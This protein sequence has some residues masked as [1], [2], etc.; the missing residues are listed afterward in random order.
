MSE[1]DEAAALADAVQK[2]RISYEQYFAGVERFEPLKE[3]DKVKKELRRLM[4]A[5]SNN[6]AFRFRVQTTQATLVTFENHWDRIVR[7]IEEGTFKRDKLRAQRQQ[8]LRDATADVDLIEDDVHDLSDDFEEIT[9]LED[10]ESAVADLLSKG[11]A[12]APGATRATG[13]TGA[14]ATM[15]NA[16]TVPTMGASGASAAG[17]PPAPRPV[18]SSLFTASDDLEELVAKPFGGAGASNASGSPRSPTE[19]TAPRSPTGT[20]GP[21]APRSPMEPTAPRSPIVA[22][23]P[24]APTATTAPRSPSGPTAPTAST[25]AT[26]PSSPAAPTAPRSPTA[27]TTTT[28]PRPS[29]GTTVP[30]VA[31]AKPAAAG[32]DLKKL[33]EAFTSARSKTGE[34]KPI[35]METLAETVRKQTA[36]VKAQLGCNDVEFKVAIKDGKAV[37]KAVPK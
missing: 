11:M 5:R 21:N 24:N 35:S 12:R 37:L 1:L 33:H 4:T 9:E 34:S 14:T 22:T 27:P 6:T 19:P 32:D 17:K 25:A 36:A 31:A 3:R 23:G 28:A 30:T 15:A 7:Q 16:P 26:A 18:G 2:L 20:T 13:S 10:R 29:T 8:A